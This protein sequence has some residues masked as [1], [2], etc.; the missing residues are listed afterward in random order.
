M[1]QFLCFASKGPPKAPPGAPFAPPKKQ[2]GAE[3]DAFDPPPKA[4]GGAPSLPERSPGAPEALPPSLL[5]A[6]RILPQWVLRI[7]FKKVGE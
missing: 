4:E 3:I 2:E 6:L 5:S 1:C 7:M